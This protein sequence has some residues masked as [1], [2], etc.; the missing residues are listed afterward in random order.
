MIS[1]AI[2][3]IYMILGEMLADMKLDLDVLA[4]YGSLHQ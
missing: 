3:I 2:H 1:H 4:S